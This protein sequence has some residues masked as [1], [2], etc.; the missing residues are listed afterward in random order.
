M[1]D[2]TK[3]LVHIILIVIGVIVYISGMCVA[4]YLG[5]VLFKKA[6]NCIGRYIMFSTTH[7]LCIVITVHKQNSM[8]SPF[9]ATT[10]IYSV[11]CPKCMEWF[12]SSALFSYS[13]FTSLISI[14]NPIMLSY[15]GSVTTVHVPCVGQYMLI[16]ISTLCK[17]SY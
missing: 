6:S 12:V 4:V 1:C 17:S 11:G 8:S 7:V 9:T 2:D 5:V 16:Q 13:Q 10:C 15:L 3:L 14:L